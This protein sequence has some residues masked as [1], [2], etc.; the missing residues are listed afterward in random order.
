MNYRAWLEV[1]VQMISRGDISRIIFHIR[2][3][4]GR[5]L[6]KLDQQSELPAISGNPCGKLVPPINI[7]INYTGRS[8]RGGGAGPGWYQTAYTA[9]VPAK[10]A[11]REVMPTLSV[12]RF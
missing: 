9:L 8:F 11:V 10:L 6:T 2:Q 12:H 1:E 5:R 4:C 7:D 3:S